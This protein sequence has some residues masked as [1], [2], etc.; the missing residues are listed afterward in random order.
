MNMTDSFHISEL[1]I[2]W[3]DLRTL[4]ANHNTQGR[5]A[6]G[7]DTIFKIHHHMQTLYLSG[8][9]DDQKNY[10]CV[11]YYIHST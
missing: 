5:I 7:Q 11:C 9:I 6:Y 2:L 3:L 10:K 1:N 4:I 8:L